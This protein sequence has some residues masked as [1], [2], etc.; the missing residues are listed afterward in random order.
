MRQRLVDRAIPSHAT[1]HG[2]SHVAQLSSTQALKPPVRPSAGN[3]LHLSTHEH[4]C[5]E[6]WVNWNANYLSCPPAKP[7]QRTQTC[8][9]SGCT[10]TRM[11]GARTSEQRARRRRSWHQ[12]TRATMPATAGAP[13]CVQ[14]QT[15]LPAGSPAAPSILWLDP[16]SQVANNECPSTRHMQAEP[17]AALS[18]TPAASPFFLSVFLHLQEE[19]DAALL[20]AGPGQHSHAGTGGWEVGEADACTTYCMNCSYV[21]MQAG[22]V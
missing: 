7:S 4:H 14:K 17:D 13:P 16:P 3:C 15:A 22:R 20:H 8:H 18:P 11:G 19:P 1:L 5:W 2:M 21:S 9:S 12:P 6:N 10:Q